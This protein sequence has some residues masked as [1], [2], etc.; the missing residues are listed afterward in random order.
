VA[1]PDPLDDCITVAIS[2]YMRTEHTTLTTL[3]EFIAARLRD[4]GYVRESVVK[5][6][7]D[8]REG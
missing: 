2:D 7:M 3:G 6:G 8:P 5:T 4:R 1:A